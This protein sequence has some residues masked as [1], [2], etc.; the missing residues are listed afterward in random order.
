MDDNIKCVYKIKCRDT[1]ITEFYIGSS[2]EF[3]KRKA[4]HII[5]INNINGRKYNYKIY[6]FIRDN[7][8]FDNWEFEIVKEYPLYNIKELQLEEQKYIKLLNPQL[9]SK[10][11]RWVFIKQFE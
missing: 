6:K 1:N 2:I 9:N 4:Q 5:D 7:G 8:D 3:N 10:V 11:P